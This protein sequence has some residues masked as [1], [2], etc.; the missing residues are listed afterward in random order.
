MNTIICGISALRYWRMPPWIALIMT[1]PEEEYRNLGFSSVD[2]FN[3]VRQQMSL[4]SPLAKECAD[5]KRWNSAGE[6]ARNI[7]NAAPLLGQCLEFPVDIMVKSRAEWSKSGIIAPVMYSKPLPP[8]STVA[9]T[10][11]ISVVTPEFALLQLAGTMTLNQCLAIASELFGTYSPYRAPRAFVEWFESRLSLVSGR[12]LMGE[13]YGWTPCVIG[14]KLHDL[15]R[16]DPLVTAGSLRATV[17]QSETNRGCAR[18]LKIAELVIPGAASPLESK[19]GLLLCLPK[20]YGGLGHTGMIH[21]YEVRL[22]KSSR[23]LAGK[24]RCYCDLYWGEGVDL[25]IQSKL[26]HDNETSFLS[27]S[28]RIA[29]LLNEGITVLPVTAHHLNDRST[30]LELSKTLARLRGIGAPTLTARQ[31]VRSRKLFDDLCALSGDFLSK[32]AI[33]RP[34]KSRRASRKPS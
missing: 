27:D 23:T 19:A 11:E 33:S 16:R 18:A 7:R 14:G 25:E 22:T 26:V 8:G 5:D 21:N 32:N 34:S 13:C 31:E 12:N 6:H 10:D 2:E 20:T 30:L 29:A 4:E 15:W 24:R 9:I 1:E 28:E 3:R 17:A